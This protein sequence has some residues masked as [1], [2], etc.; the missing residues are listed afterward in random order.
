MSL[1]ELSNIQKVFTRGDETIYALK[2][3]SLTISKG[4]FASL[5]GTSGC[6]KSTLLHIIGLLDVATSGTYVLDGKN[7]SD[8]TDYERTRIRSQMLGFIFQSFFLLPRLSALDNVI[9]PLNYL[10]P[11]ISKNEKIERAQYMLAQ[12][13]LKDRMLNLPN[14]LSGGQ[15]QRV[16]IARALINNPSLILADEPTGNL[17]SKTSRGILDLFVELHEKHKATIIIVT[18]DEDVAKLTKRQIRLSDGSIV[19]A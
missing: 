18:H 2:D 1:V 16:A 17:D 12:V 3:V 13:G 14:Q 8:T 7:V 5:I 19:N 6:G 9:M 10:T 15:R 11:K 4:E